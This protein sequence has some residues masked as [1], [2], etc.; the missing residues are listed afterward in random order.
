MEIKEYNLSL[1]VDFYSLLFKGH[2]EV[3]VVNSEKDL[4]LD[5][6]GLKINR[7]ELVGKNIPF[8]Q[9]DSTKKLKIRDLPKDATIE[10]DYEGK[11]TERA[12]Y[13]VYKSKY[14]S[15][16]F[17]TTDFEPNGARLLFPC[18]DNPSFKA[19]FSL[20]VTT[21]RSL[22][23][24]SNGKTKVVTDLGDKTKHVFE[25]TPKMSTYI[26]Y[27]GIGNFD[28]SS[29]Q[30]KNVEF[31]IFARPGNAVKGKYALENAAKFLRAYEEYYGIK[32]PLAK[33][34]LIGLPEYAS[35]AMENWGA[36]T[37][38]EIVLLIDENSSV[39]N[40]RRVTSVL[41]HEI[42][43][44]W[45]GDLVTMRWWNDLWLNESFATFMESKM[46]DKIYPEWNVTSDFVL[47][48]TAGSMHSDSLSSTHPIDA[49]VNA[50]EEISQIFDEISYGK[51]AS[52][53]RMIEDWI[54]KEAFRTG[55][56]SYLSKFKYANAEGTDLWKSLEDA[57]G[58]PVSET[59]EVW[60]KKPGF[61]IVSLSLDHNKLRFSQERF[62]LK[63]KN[64][65][66]DAWP[67]PITCSINHEERKFVMKDRVLELPVKDVEE[68]KV[69]LGQTGFYRVLYDQTLYSII[70]RE[71]DSLAALDRWGVVSDLFAFLIA[72][73]VTMEQY[74]KLAKRASNETDYLVA[75]AVTTQLQ[76]LRFLSPE[77]PLVK[78]IYA[79][80][81]QTQ[82]KRLGLD[83]KDGEKDTDKILRGRIATGLALV[84][85]SF[86]QELSKRF[87]R[88][89]TLDPNLRV[90]VAVSF[91]QT[92]GSESFDKL[93]STMKRMGNEADVV[94]IYFGLT[95][96]RDPKLIEKTLDLCIS[97]EISRA[98]SLYAVIDATQNPYVRET[99]WNWVQKNFHVFRELFQ[100]TPYVSQLMQEVISKTGIGREEE[101]KDYVSNLDIAE[102]HE[103]IRKGLELL[104]IYSSL[105][106]R[107]D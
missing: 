58:Q 59:M 102:A 7:V 65:S 87:D 24:I 37:F 83:S 74:V 55:V 9:D 75:D 47:E 69:N 107:L 98:D 41:G 70:E 64:P 89:E 81:H 85:K 67:I 95:S 104:D 97:G 30:D 56:S 106:K 53:L 52:V 91:A 50:P 15:D 76:F 92:M 49:K 103:G 44:M 23:V 80:H 46:T 86:A 34:D 48:E 57:S 99:T 96:F 100:G 26:F 8:E 19:V 72:A 39:S 82:I 38:R 78:E 25:K 45:F 14:G 29:I 21:Q 60:V 63:S 36:I 32:Y 11:V 28:Q 90:A 79:N 40:R 101:V 2:E 13:G 61:P 68:L 43:H 31:R 18:V 71:F 77:N 105:K 66:S 42:A 6:F 35:G 5:S 1:D 62:V 20:E 10:I 33:L 4:I 3:V 88:Y 84:D 16:Y 93:V 51:G 94:K 22:K 12:L 27:L 73:R 54:G 17:V